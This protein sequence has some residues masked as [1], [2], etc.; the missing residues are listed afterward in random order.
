MPW[1]LYDTNH[2]RLG[3]QQKHLNCL[4]GEVQRR[5]PDWSKKTRTTDDDEPTLGPL[6]C[7]TPMGKRREDKGMSPHGGGGSAMG[8]RGNGIRLGQKEDNRHLLS[9]NLASSH[10]LIR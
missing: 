5:G 3:K 9:Q 2:G 4:L 6:L 7:P 1:H 10:V 8:T